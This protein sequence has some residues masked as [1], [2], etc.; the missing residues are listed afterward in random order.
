VTGFNAIEARLFSSNLGIKYN[1]TTTNNNN[2]PQWAPCAACTFGPPCIF[3]VSE[4]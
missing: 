2:N 4:F 1:T 3:V